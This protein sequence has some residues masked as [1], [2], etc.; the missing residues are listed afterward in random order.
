MYIDQSVCSHITYFIC[1]FSVIS[2][3]YLF[4]LVTYGITFLGCYM[5]TDDGVAWDSKTNKVLTINGKPVENDTIYKATMAYATVF[6]AMDDVRPIV[7]YVR[8]KQGEN[9]PDFRVFF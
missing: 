5:Q 9:D 6:K 1:H 8:K 2:I 7:E 3:I 4:I